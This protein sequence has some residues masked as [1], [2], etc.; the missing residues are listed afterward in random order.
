MQ[1]EMTMMTVDR[2][3]NPQNIRLT[4]GVIVPVGGS[5]MM[6]GRVPGCGVDGRIACDTTTPC[7]SCTATGEANLCR[8]NPSQIAYAKYAS[9]LLRDV[10]GRMAC[11]SYAKYAS[12]LLQQ[13]NVIAQRCMRCGTCVT[14]RHGFCTACGMRLKDR[15]IKTSQF[16][17]RQS[18]YPSREKAVR[19]ARLHSLNGSKRGKAWT[20]A[21]LLTGE[22]VLTQPRLSEV[23]AIHWTAFNKIP[24]RLTILPP[25]LQLSSNPNGRKS[26][27]SDEGRHAEEP[28]EIFTLP[29]CDP[30]RAEEQST[31]RLPS[32]SE[33]CPRDNAEI[34]WSP[35]N[36]NGYKPIDH[37]QL[38]SS[39]SQVPTLQ[40]IIMEPHTP[41]NPG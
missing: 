33:V 4:G 38:A 16:H 7:G 28:K 27:E 2:T 11:D 9:T 3:T 35:T 18:P 14:R 6:I 34:W 41:K 19:R 21:S 37:C 23:A 17:V 1:E 12:T 39:S 30:A 20:T 32:L 29:E 24:Q 31:R 5:S 8:P 36:S 22:P 15:Q 26:S 25:P 13:G 40:R 10:D